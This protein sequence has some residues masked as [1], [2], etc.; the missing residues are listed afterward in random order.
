MVLARS[1]LKERSERALMQVVG[2]KCIKILG[3]AI[4]EYF[5]L[6]FT[7]T[8]MGS[9]AAVLAT[10]PSFIFAYTG[11]SLSTIVLVMALIAVN[12]IGLDLFLCN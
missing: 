8:G 11:M 12:W 1:V 9:M 4:A 10:L 3:M 2:L 5:L 6:L 7:G